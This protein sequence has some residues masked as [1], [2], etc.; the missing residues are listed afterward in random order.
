M[1]EEKYCQRCKSWQPHTNEYVSRWADI[2][3]CDA[4]GAEEAEIANGK[5]KATKNE[6]EFILMLGKKTNPSR[7]EIDKFIWYKRFERFSEIVGNANR[8]RKEGKY[9]KKIKNKKVRV[10]L[11]AQGEFIFPYLVDRDCPYVKQVAEVVKIFPNYKLGELHN[12]SG[13]GEQEF[14]RAMLWIAQYE[15]IWSGEVDLKE[16]LASECA[17]MGVT[18]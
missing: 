5:M 6:K 9:M 18:L 4:C 2:S 3:M 17:K 14:M 15:F 7:E 16:F 1:K 11:T 12:W 13:L 8:N 10:N